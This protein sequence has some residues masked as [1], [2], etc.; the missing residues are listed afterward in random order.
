MTIITS[1]TN[2][3][4]KKTKKLLQKK[5]RSHSY[6]IEGWHL[7]TEAEQAGAVF[8][9]IFVTSELA[10]RVRG[11][12]QVRLVTEDVLK[13][14]TESPSP[15]G[16]VAEVAMPESAFPDW[17]AGRFLLLDDIQ[18]PGNLGTMVRTAAAA[19]LTGVF[20]SEKSADI[21]NQKTL[22]AMQGSHFYIPIYRTNLLEVCSQLQQHAVPVFATSLAKSALDYRKLPKTDNFAF[23]MGNEGQG[24]SELLLQKADRLVHIPMPG[25]TESLNVAVAAG[26][27]IFSLI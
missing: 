24:I 2:N 8:N 27:I 7:F 14:L 1:K 16:I 4:I 25:E 18:D 19:G 23:I 5:H 11:F 17:T 20:I 12:E 10:D 21:Y 22:R 13:T 26:I 15:Q 6:L 3:L 9:N